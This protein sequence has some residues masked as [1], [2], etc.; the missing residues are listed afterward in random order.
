MLLSVT[1]MLCVQAD[2]GSFDLL[3]I[4]GQVRHGDPYWD[5]EM[6]Y[7][8]HRYDDGLAMVDELL[9]ASPGDPELY[10]HKVRFMFEVVERVDRTD[11]GIDKM[12]WY[13]EMLAV[14]EAGLLLAPDHGHL[15]FG[16]GVALGRYG[17]TKGVL[18]SLSL[19]KP[20]ESS[21]QRCADSDY[22]YRSLA[23][24]EMLPCDCLHTLGIFYRLVPDS[25]VVDL[26]AGTRGSLDKSLE[27]NQRADSCKPDD[28]SIEKELGVTQICL[29][30][31]RRDES[32]VTAGR[33][34]LLHLGSLPVRTPSDEIDQAHARQILFDPSLACGYSRDGQQD[35]DQEKLEAQ[36]P[37]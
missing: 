26:I 8:Q 12:S 1:M 17:T 4:P 28:I 9:A 32:L 7:H 21:W 22:R 18:S 36:A 3:E 29:G 27:Y 30:Q 25:W 20:I 14:A 6:L 23:G 10:W 13:E 19:A 33:A 31:K 24:E 34:H 5:L 16:K 2:E 37:R 11:T 15:L 35:L